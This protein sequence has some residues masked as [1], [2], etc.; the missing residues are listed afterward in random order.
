MEH[1]KTKT[2]KTFFKRR[3]TRIFLVVIALLVIVRII[4]PYVVLHY[5]NKTLANMHGYFGHVQDVDLAIYRGA[6]KIKDV[7]IHKSDTITHQETEFIDAK[8]I[9][10]S[11]E[12]SALLDGR[13]AGELE[14]QDPVLCFTKDKAEPGQIAKDTNDFRVVLKKFMPLDINRFE[15]IDGIIKYK[16]KGSSPAVDIQMD[17]THILAENLT[18][19]KDTAMLPATVTASANIYKG[20]LTFNMKLD[21]LAKNPTFDLNA[22]LENTNLPELN[23]F[24]KAYGKIDVNKGS[25]GLFTEL[26][27]KDNKFIGYVKPVIKDLDV[28]GPEDK[29]DNIL[30]KFWEG[31]VGTA[32]VAFTNQK[33]DQIATKIPLKG[34]ITGTKANLWYAVLDILRNAFVQALSHSIDE[35]IG[36]GS[37]SEVEAP[38]KKGIL[39]KIFGSKNKQD[40][41][42]EAEGKKK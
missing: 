13:I 41:E 6:Y 5:A 15:I 10:L 9:D 29:N 7:Y 35:E 32:G 4:L 11:V 20:S 1:K 39:K 19:V 18:N 25:F 28:L 2:K 42:K 24:F 30:Q 37:V 40:R 22:N 3:G 8:M 23:S 14:V 12:W 21:P 38:E 26:A 33:H 16:D 31:F 27:A 34:T 17:N 36:I